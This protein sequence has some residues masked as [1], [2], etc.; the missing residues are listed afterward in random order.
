LCIN[1]YIH[2]IQKAIHT[3]GLLLSHPIARLLPARI[4]LKLCYYHKTGQKL[5]LRKPV[6]FNEK[7]QWLKLY[8]RQP[9]YSNL[10]D[11]YEVRKY[12]AQ[13]IGKKYSIPLLGMWNTVD[14]IPFDMLPDQFVLKCTHDSGGLVFCKNK[15][16]FDTV[17]TCDFLKK[18]LTKNWYWA[19]REWAYKKIKP[20]IIAEKLMVDES[21]IELKDYKI[22]CF[23][24]EPRIIQVDFERFTE[25]KRNFYSP[26]WEFQPFA[27][28]YPNRPNIVIPKPQSLDLMLELAKKLSAGKI[29]T[30]VD[31]YVIKNEIYFGELT[32]Y[33]EGGYGSFV[34]SEW[35]RVFGDWITL[36]L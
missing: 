35:N 6:L 13:T 33:P 25:H 1:G 10:V 12:V 7:L 2:K 11:K 22:F 18:R 8:D 19:G 31:M 29:F 28:K 9:D 21:G 20:R 5:D 4:F 15:H 3:P 23:N 17:S 24:S 14:E 27:L 36:P 16:S 32:F 26:Q 34:P 30:R